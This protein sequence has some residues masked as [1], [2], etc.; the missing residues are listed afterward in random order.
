MSALKKKQ[1]LGKGMMKK[2]FKFY[3]LN[4]YLLI[5]RLKLRSVWGIFTTCCLHSEPKKSLKVCRLSRLIWN[6]LQLGLLRIALSPGRLN[7]QRP[8]IAS[9][10]IVPHTA[11]RPGRI[12]AKKK[13]QMKFWSKVAGCDRVYQLN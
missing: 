6:W 7:A 13:Q 5:Q 1:F 9:V 8:S 12:L 11:I 3:N 2:C 10:S 4:A